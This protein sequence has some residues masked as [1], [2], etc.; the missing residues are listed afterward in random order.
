MTLDKALAYFKRFDI[1]VVE[2]GC[3]GTPGTHH[4]D[5]QILL[6]D[7][8]A[9]EEFKGT[10][11][12]HGMR[13]SAFSCHGNPVHPVPE[14]AAKYDSIMRN[15][16]LL[17]EK[18]GVDT[19]CGFSGC[20]GSEDNSKYPHWCTTVWPFDAVVS[21]KYQWEQKLI[22]YWKEFAVFARQHH[23]N[24]IAIEMHPGFNVYNPA[25]LLRLREACGPEIGV[26]FDPSHL[27]WQGI[28]IPTAIRKLR[29]CIFHFHAKDTCIDELEM[30]KN[31]FFDLT[32]AYSDN[33]KSF[34]FR[35]PGNG[36]GSSYW[37]KII[38]ALSQ[39]GY[40]GAISIEH[41]DN[42]MGREE[43]IQKSA[44]FLNKI[45]IKEQGTGQPWK[46]P[47]RNYQRTFLPK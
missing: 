45:L 41:E 2:L 17:A 37:K 6:N 12:K 27:I 14:I 22:P 11:N 39:A 26:N 25:T 30:G 16:V 1:E 35:I 28:D 44:A 31:G 8:K 46:D 32:G 47:I 43:G 34:S 29:D 15:A 9:L 33:Y 21:N 38:A 10:L 3:G 19:I 40:T 23:V 13:I 24:H 5:P 18:M 7:E 4:C 36:T 42:T 20:P